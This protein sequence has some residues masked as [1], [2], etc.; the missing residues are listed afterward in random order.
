MIDPQAL[1]MLIDTLRQVLN[2]LPV[3][4]QDMA[5]MIMNTFLDTIPQSLKELLLI[6]A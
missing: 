4:S 5:N 2:N 3:I 1:I 6:A